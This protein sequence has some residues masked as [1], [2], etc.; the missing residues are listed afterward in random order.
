MATAIGMNN[1]SGSLART[2]LRAKPIVAMLLLVALALTATNA[3]NFTRA[4]AN[5]VISADAWYFLD[6]CP[7][8]RC[9]PA[10]RSR[11]P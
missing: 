9:S 10:Q 5:P 3:F 2:A 8:A 1:P 11:R 6:I 7:P 4:V